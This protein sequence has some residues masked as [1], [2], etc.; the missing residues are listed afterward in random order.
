MYYC[1]TKKRRKRVVME[2][3]KIATAEITGGER[4]GKRWRVNPSSDPEHKL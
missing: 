4:L 1:T 3:K 2:R